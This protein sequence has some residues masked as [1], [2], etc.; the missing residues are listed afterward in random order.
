MRRILF[1]LCSGSVLFLLAAPATL[2]QT[3]D[4]PLG[5]VA[6]VARQHKPAPTPGERVY[7]NDNLPG[8]GVISTVGASDDTAKPADQTQDQANSD[9]AGANKSDKDKNGTP[10]ADDQKKANDE[11]AGKISEQKQE[12]SRLERELNVLQRESQIHAAV[13]YADVGSRLGNNAKYAEEDKQYQQQIADKQK[14]LDEAKQKLD[15]MQEEARK[16]GVPA[17]KRD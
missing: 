1:L 6:R 12:I 16:E 4:Q 7:D 14:A 2:A 9:N 5:D 15:S 11:W 10:S 17:A 13:N 8:K 3:G